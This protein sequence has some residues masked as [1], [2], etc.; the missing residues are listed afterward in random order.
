MAKKLKLAE[1]KADS[2]H[3]STKRR[4]NVT[5]DDHLEDTQDLLAERLR[6]GDRVAAAEL[7]DKYYRQIFLYMRR[8]GH[9]RQVSEDLTQECFLN[10]WYHIGHLKED[11][12][13]AGWLYRIASNVSK[14]YWRRHKGKQ[15]VSI[16]WVD[17]PED[18]ILETDRSDNYEQLEQLRQAVAQLP[19]K[20]R[21]VIVLHYLQHLTISEAAEAAGIRQG[22][23]KSRLSRALKILRKQL[24]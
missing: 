21:E 5:K 19:I 20:L 14:L 10:A 4:N 3:L 6:N 12:A 9:N 16:E 15:M 1:H 2:A 24:P 11:K 13:L 7:V 23:F 18:R 17:T 22:T 8:L